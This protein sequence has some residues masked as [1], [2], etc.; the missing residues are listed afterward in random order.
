MRRSL[1][2]LTLALFAVGCS[3]AKD[4]FSAHANVA[5][6]AADQTLSA[7]SLAALLQAAKGARL[8]PET[9]EFLANLWVDFQL[10]GTGIAEGKIGTDSATIVQVMWPEITE[11][12]GTR[13][14]DQLMEKRTAFTPAG[15][16]SVYNATDAGAVRVLQHFLVRVQPTATEAQRTAA[17]RKAAGLLARVRG[18]ANFGQVATQSTDDQASR[19]TG[20]VMNAAPRGMYV[21]PFDSAGWLLKPG[22]ITGLVSTPFGYHVIRRPPL[23]EVRAQIEEYLRVMAG[24]RLD[25]L[26][27][28][29]LGTAKN[30][31]VKSGVPAAVRS[32]IEDVNSHRHSGKTLASYEGGEFTVRDLL[33]WTGSA[34]QEITDQLKSATDSQVAG[35]VRALAL[36]TLLIADARANGIDLS[37]EEYQALRAGYLAGLD[38][39]KF[40]LGLNSDVLDSTAS[41]ADRERA[42]ASTMS[43]YVNKLLRREV[44]A[45]LIPGGLASYLRD[46]L[47]YSINMAGVTRAV[48]IALTSRD[49]TAAGAPTGGLTLPQGGPSP[50]PQ[51]GGGR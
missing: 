6:E 30:L 20:G 43:A 48:E 34:P 22:E 24:R 17:E 32:A 40:A 39:L 45:R 42:V 3:G 28:D 18:G 21:T 14:H 15:I 27:M 11:A 36:N 9:A 35:F 25:S 7:D 51:V 37:T 41:A 23:S 12:I 44:P 50:T 13:W 19:A 38:T 1:L 46:E 26:Y 4:M 47:S 49:S 33:R 31:R 16:D 8:T 5:A 2:C 29:S 10:F